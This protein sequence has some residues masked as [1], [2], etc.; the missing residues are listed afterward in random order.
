MPCFLVFLLKNSIRNRFS[1]ASLFRRHKK[2]DAWRASFRPALEALGRYYK[3]SSNARGSHTVVCILHCEPA[4]ARRLKQ[5]AAVASTAT[6][7]QQQGLFRPAL[8]ALGR[9]YKVRV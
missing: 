9:Y 5:Q 6:A 3:V 8:E 4:A 1:A 2:S 7:E